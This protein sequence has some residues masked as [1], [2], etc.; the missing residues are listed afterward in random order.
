MDLLAVQFAIVYD[1]ALPDQIQVDDRGLAM[2]RG[3]F[4]LI[5]AGF[6][7]PL[8]LGD[9]S[10][11]LDCCLDRYGFLLYGYIWA[12]QL[13]VWLDK[14]ERNLCLALTGLLHLQI[15]ERFGQVLM[16]VAV[17]AIAILGML[18]LVPWN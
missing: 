2:F 12:V 5:L 17:H 15:D 8:T 3:R 9:R 13:M 7:A 16:Q 11:A 1:C 10:H 14:T 6:V 4:L 18:L